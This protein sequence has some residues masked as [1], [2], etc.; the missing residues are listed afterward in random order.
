MLNIIFD[1]LAY[2]CLAVILIALIMHVHI[3]Q[4]GTRGDAPNPNFRCVPP[5]RRAGKGE[6]E[7]E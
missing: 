6:E 5:A 4:T 2:A 3:Q 1:V 7:A